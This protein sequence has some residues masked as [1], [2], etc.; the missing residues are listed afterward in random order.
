MLVTCINDSDFGVLAKPNQTSRAF[1]WIIFLSKFA[2][3]LIWS[4]VYGL[5]VG[6]PLLGLLCFYQAGMVDSPVEVPPEVQAQ[7]SENPPTIH[8]APAAHPRRQ[9]RFR[10]KQLTGV[11][12][13]D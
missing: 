9:W 1:A 12:R 11:V 7:V 4:T 2:G 5:E 8:V 3:V 10:G 13:A 6:L